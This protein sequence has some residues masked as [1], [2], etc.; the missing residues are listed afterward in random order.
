MAKRLQGAI[1]IT[2]ASCAY[3][4]ARGRA[5]KL[6]RNIGVE[7]ALDT[8]SVEMLPGAIQALIGTGIVTDTV[9]QATHQIAYC[10]NRGLHISIFDD[11]TIGG[12]ESVAC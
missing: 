9:E 7:H 4:V 5:P 8:M 3:E 1:K 10:R 2:E 12:V 6:T 11:G